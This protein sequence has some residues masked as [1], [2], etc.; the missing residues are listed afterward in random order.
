V[1]L[2]KACT[3]SW[4]KINECKEE[5]RRIALCMADNYYGRIKIE[6]N[7]ESIKKDAKIYITEYE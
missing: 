6:I 1:V 5:L 7:V 4:L 2:E 3:R